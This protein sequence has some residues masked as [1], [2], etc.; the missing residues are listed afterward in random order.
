MCII[1]CALPGCGSGEPPGNSTTAADKTEDQLPDWQPNT[2]KPLIAMHYMPWFNNP[3]TSQRGKSEWLHWSWSDSAID[4][5]PERLDPD[6]KREIA[7]VHYPLIGPYSSDNQ[8]VVRYHF[9]TAKSVGI[10]LVFVIW[11]GPGSETDELLPMLLEEASATGLKLAICYEE[12]LNWPPYRDPKNRAEIIQNASDDLNYIL[13]HY[14]A[15]PA[16]LHRGSEPFIFQFNFWGDGPLGQQNLLPAEWDE[17]FAKLNQPI[18]YARQ[19]LNPEYH[20]TIEGAYIWWT[21]D[22]SYIEDFSSFSRALVDAGELD[23]FMTMAAPGFDDRGVNGWGNGPRVT[24]RDHLSIFEK[25]FEQAFVGDPEIIQLVTWND[26]NEGTAIEPTLEKG[27]R[28]LNA[29][30]TWI[31]ERTGRTV[32]L[33]DN[34]EPFESYLETSTPAQ[35]RQLPKINSPRD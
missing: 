21:D 20:P 15:H 30:E 2:G 33:D 4:R 26:F 35:K 13:Q 9:R 16:Y 12:K 27:Y 24:P 29:L 34:K 5:N 1:L 28:Y 17:V 32:N 18:T 31:G 23:F 11:Y 10:D 25:T 7:S 6:G 19:N 8:N 3:H 22:D 14:S